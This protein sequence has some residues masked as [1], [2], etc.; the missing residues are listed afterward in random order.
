MKTRRS[1]RLGTWGAAVSTA[2]LFLCVTGC[3]RDNPDDTRSP[4]QQRASREL[5]ADFERAAR[6]S[7]T[8]QPIAVDPSRA[9]VDPR[10]EPVPVG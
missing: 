1:R 2:A 6:A 8:D 10:A 5:G 9:K 3:S 4:E 7:P